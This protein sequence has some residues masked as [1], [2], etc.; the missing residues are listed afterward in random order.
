VARQFILS[1]EDDLLE[2]PRRNE[3][4][5]V[6]TLAEKG[7]LLYY[8]NGCGIKLQ[9]SETLCSLGGTVQFVFQDSPFYKHFADQFSSRSTLEQNPG[10]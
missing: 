2:Q 4:L 7:R 1:L 3:E 5:M 8:V 6:I 9:Q 10:Q